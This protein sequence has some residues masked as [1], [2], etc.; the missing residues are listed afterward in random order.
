[1]RESLDN[2]FTSPFFYDLASNYVIEQ[3]NEM[4][5]AIKQVAESWLKEKI[6]MDSVTYEIPEVDEE[7]YISLL[8]SE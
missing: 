3:T 2:L 6:K 5:I 8:L 7:E 1:M 4:D